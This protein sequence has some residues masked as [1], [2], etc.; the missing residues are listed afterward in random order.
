[1]MLKRTKPGKVEIL[2]V[3]Y[4]ARAHKSIYNSDVTLKEVT[5]NQ[6]AQ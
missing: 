2:P 4:V 3:S 6:L 5:I 1:M